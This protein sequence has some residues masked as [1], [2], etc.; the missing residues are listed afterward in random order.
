MVQLALG[1]N[2]QLSLL[3]K[4]FPRATRFVLK[5]SILSEFWR[6]NFRSEVQTCFAFCLVQLL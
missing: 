1:S 5:I 2:A 3:G 4:M 6:L